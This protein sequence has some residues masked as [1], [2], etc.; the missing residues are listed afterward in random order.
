MQH[1]M[2][3]SGEALGR[4]TFVCVRNLCYWVTFLVGCLVIA[5]SWRIFIAPLG[6]KYADR[7]ELYI[8]SQR[9]IAQPMCQDATEL[10]Q[11]LRVNECAYHRRRVSDGIVKGAIY[12]FANSFGVCQM[13]GMC[14]GPNDINLT[15]AIPFL[16]M[17]A[18]IV[19]VALWCMSISG[20]IS[21]SRAS[22]I[23]H[24][25]ARFT[26]PETEQ[27][28]YLPQAIDDAVMQ[29]VVHD[30]LMHTSVVGA[31]FN[32]DNTDIGATPASLYHCDD[33][34]AKRTTRGGGGGGGLLSG[35]L[36]SA[37]FASLTTTREDDDEVK[38][39]YV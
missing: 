24:R 23:E 22:A 38:K 35:G 8:Q 1:N 5:S 34:A 12:D 19:G 29:R 14:I 39:K 10:V 17:I 27:R 31:T 3:G 32:D 11:M 13:F 15:Y 25:I 36:L 21:S 9:Y 28:R 30:K 16:F 2:H 7:A 20:I 26:L 37:A 18:V 6:E 33:T 4:Q